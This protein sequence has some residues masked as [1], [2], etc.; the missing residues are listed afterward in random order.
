MCVQ[1]VDPSSAP[2]ETV[3]LHTPDENAIIQEYDGY[4]RNLAYHYIPR[5]MIRAD[6]LDLEIDEL[7]QTVRV[8]FWE[9][10]SRREIKNYK[11][12]LRRMMHNEAVNYR[13]KA[14][15]HQVLDTDEEGE[16]YYGDLLLSQNEGTLDPLEIL[17]EKETISEYIQQAVDAVMAFPPLQRKAILCVFKDRVDYLH[18]LR[19]ALHTNHIDFKQL[20]WSGRQAALHSMKVSASLAKKKLKALQKASLRA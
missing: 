6:I 2:E 16:P 12:Y 20:D 18:E 8:K 10:L 14:R 5:Q 9:A 17:I 7:I 1:L 13:R 11:A 15:F 19:E 4:I 3:A